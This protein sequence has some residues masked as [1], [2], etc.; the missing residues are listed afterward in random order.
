[1]KRLS[2]F[3]LILSVSVIG[4]IFTQCSNKNSAVDEHLKV[5]ATALN[6]RCPM[7]ID[8]E[9]RLDSAKAHP[10][11][12]FVF[13][14]SLLVDGAFMDTV[15]FKSAMASSLINNV[16]TN[17]DMAYYRDNEVTLYYQYNDEN[18]K[19]LCRIAITPKDYKVINK[20]T[21]GK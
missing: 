8:P 4:F 15:V 11:K 14:Y 9:T 7:T 16:M 5:A 17:K 13:H 20:N 1:M 10:E 19:Y 6:E 2:K 18:K 3:L 12:L 21:S